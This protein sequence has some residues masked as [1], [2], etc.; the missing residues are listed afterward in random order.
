M[1]L[2]R[3]FDKQKIK[4]KMVQEEDL[5]QYLNSLGVYQN[6][7]D[8][9]VNCRFCGLII[10]MENLQALFPYEDKICFVCSNAKCISRI[11]HDK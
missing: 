4:I 5:V 7:L 3:I 10:T 1:K 6:I 9:K 8:R 2:F 11:S